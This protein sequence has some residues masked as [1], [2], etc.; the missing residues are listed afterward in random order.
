MRQIAFHHFLSLWRCARSTSINFVFPQICEMFSTFN[1][2]LPE[3]VTLQTLGVFTRKYILIAAHKS[4]R[5]LVLN[6][7]PFFPPTLYASKNSAVINYF[8]N[9]LGFYPFSFFFSFSSISE[10]TSFICQIQ[11]FYDYTIRFSLSIQKLCH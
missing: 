3:L 5:E 6:S 10:L 7:Q 2:S 9:L 11:L 4:N 1:L 8:L